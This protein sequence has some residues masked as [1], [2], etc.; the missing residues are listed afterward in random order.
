MNP[1]S[2]PQAF[3]AFAVLPCAG[4]SARM[5]RPKLL[6]PWK[7]RLVI[8]AVLD[9]WR[10]SRVEEIVAVV[11]PDD[12]A[13]A[14]VCRSHGATTLAPDAPPPDMKASIQFGLQWLSAHRRPTEADVWLTAPADMPLLPGE[15]VDLLLAAHHPS[16]P[17]ILAPTYQGRKGHPVLFPW[18]LVTEVLSLPAD[19]GLN[20]ITS[21]Q[22]VVEI[23]CPWPGIL[24]DLD[25]PDDYQRL[26]LSE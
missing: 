18:P 25:T 23:D 12:H 15:A 16:A 10:S 17:G 11:H 4:R 14:K 21:R 5:G 22:P 3:R 24:A 19:K 2:P 1:P 6:L 13:L 20:L 26:R 9:A 8:E 7:G